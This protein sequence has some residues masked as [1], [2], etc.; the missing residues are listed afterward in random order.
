MGNIDAML[1]AAVAARLIVVLEDFTAVMDVR[2]ARAIFVFLCGTS[3]IAIAPML[4]LEFKD[5]ALVVFVSLVE[6][7]GKAAFV[8]YARAES[9]RTTPSAGSRT[10]GI[11]ESCFLR[12][13]DATYLSHARLGTPG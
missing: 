3:V 9:L 11:F 8:I 12:G 6:C 2:F 5:S 13:C 10:E 1:P 7:V 4:P